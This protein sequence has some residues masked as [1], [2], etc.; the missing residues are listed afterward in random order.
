VPGISVHKGVVQ[1]GEVSVGGPA[2]ATIDV[3]PP[4]QRPCRGGFV[5][6]ADVATRRQRIEDNR[7]ALDEAAQLGAQTLWL[8]C[9]DYRPAAGT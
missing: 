6:A 7:R 1:V 5:P 8:V 9:G 4:G 2:Y 3:T